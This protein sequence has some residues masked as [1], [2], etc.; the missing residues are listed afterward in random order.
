ML[1]AASG[2]LLRLDEISLGET[3]PGVCHVHLPIVLRNSQN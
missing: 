2:A 1:E 3:H